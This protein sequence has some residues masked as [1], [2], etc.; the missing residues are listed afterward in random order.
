MCVF[1]GDFSNIVSLLDGDKTETVFISESAVKTFILTET[2]KGLQTSID[3][4]SHFSWLVSKRGSYQQT[5]CVMIILYR[6]LSLLAPLSLY[7]IRAL[8]RSHDHRN[9][10]DCFTMPIFRLGQP[11]I[12]QCV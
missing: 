5:H 6:R 11:K 2:E 10:Q 1:D 8:I 7:D 4:I 3:F 12:V 9:C